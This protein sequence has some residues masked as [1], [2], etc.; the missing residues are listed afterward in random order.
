[1]LTNEIYIGK[2]SVAGVEG[3]VEEYRII[4]DGLFEQA[5]GIMRRFEDGNGAKRPPMPEDRRRE[6]IE[7]VFNG[8]LEF[9]KKMEVKERGKNLPR[10]P[11]TQEPQLEK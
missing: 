9:L 10:L 5:K 1:M 2:Y 3:Q 8:Y 6:K 11:A 4:E 7:R